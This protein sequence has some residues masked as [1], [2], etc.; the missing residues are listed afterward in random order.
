MLLGLAFLPCL[1]HILQEASEAETV[2]GL[3]YEQGSFCW[4]KE[5]PLGRGLGPRE[6]KGY[7][8]TMH[9]GTA[10]LAC[11]SPLFPTTSTSQTKPPLS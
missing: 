7:G 9:K 1:C 10:P 8:R 4:R 11:R 2:A 6:E 5:E 3:G